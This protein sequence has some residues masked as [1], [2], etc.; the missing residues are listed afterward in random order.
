MILMRF[1]IVCDTFDDLVFLQ[2]QSLLVFGLRCQKAGL[3]YALRA[4]QE[5]IVPHS[6]DMVPAVSSCSCWLANC[7]L[8]F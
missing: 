2:G 3:E 5:L 7:N 4:K 6:P 1:A 8:L